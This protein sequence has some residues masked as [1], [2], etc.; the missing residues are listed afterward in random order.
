VSDDGA[1]EGPVDG[2]DV[3]VPDVDEAIE[4][5]RGGFGVVYQA[6][7]QKLD[8]IVALKVLEN[9]VLDDAGRLRFT[10]ECRALGALST[11]PNVMTIFDS[12]FTANGYPYLMLEFLPDGSLADRI[13]RE[14]ALDVAHATEYMV[15][16]AGA[17]E[18]AHRSGVLHRDLKPANIL[19]GAFDEPKLGD[20]GI[21]R[22]EG[23]AVT[24]TSTVWASPVH[25]PPEIISGK[26]ATA[27]SDV[28][29]MGSTLY[30]LLA[31]SSAFLRDTDDSIV[32]LLTRVAI[33]DPPDLRPLGVPEGVWSVLARAMSKDP[34]ERQGS[35]FEFGSDLRTA[36]QV[37]GLPLGDMRVAKETASGA[38]V[39][40]NVPPPAATQAVS[41]PP[42]SPAPDAATSDHSP[43]D[44]RDPSA[45]DGAAF[46]TPVPPPATF[47]TTPPGALGTSEPV[48]PPPADEHT[49]PG[50]TSIPT[51]SA[52]KKDR[53]LQIAIAAVVAAVIISGTLVAVS[54]SNSTPQPPVAS[55]TVAPLS[56]T[57]ADNGDST[58]TAAPAGPI[59]LVKALITTKDVPQGSD[60]FIDAQSN[61]AFFGFK[62]APCN[63]TLD[64]STIT[65]QKQTT[66]KGTAPDGKDVQ[67]YQAVAQFPTEA[68]AEAFMSELEP[69]IACEQWVDPVGADHDIIP[70][71]D[72]ASVG[73]QSLYFEDIVTDAGIDFDNN[74]AF[75]RID[76][77]IGLIIYV[78]V[79]PND[80]ELIEELVTIGVERLEQTIP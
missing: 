67:L 71:T 32:Q 61:S 65:T 5:G 50:A 40:T 72:E 17:L 74:F 13:E 43:D 49:Q 37:I 45:H 9:A 16:I 51:A 30:E 4:I 26:R 41:Y 36:R 77:Y 24:A 12:G 57:T 3:G 14:G 27:R 6:R 62:L 39:I 31:G 23:M 1:A 29:M 48:W 69:S 28:Y 8:R 79:S 78:S 21:A 42:T 66:L 58:T 76:R 19:V 53:R 56:T 7:Q 38:P 20:F 2:V 55:S 63:E 46:D 18:T 70:L 54:L 80:E 33:E 59:D 64:T 10:R 47:V 11:H 75:Y 34:D 25:A 22:V 35:A 73:D 52:A 68:D 44:W 60:W 15:K